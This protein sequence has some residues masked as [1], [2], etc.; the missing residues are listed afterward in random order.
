MRKNA[1]LKDEL[2]GDASADLP[3]PFIMW[4]KIGLGTIFEHP[5]QVFFLGVKFCHLATKE[6]AV[7]VTGSPE[8]FQ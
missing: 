8:G 1:H 7:V 6:R 5:R 3:S 2:E 4:L